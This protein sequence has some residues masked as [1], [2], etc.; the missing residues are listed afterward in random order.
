MLL[1]QYYVLTGKLCLLGDD[2]FYQDTLSFNTGA[3]TNITVFAQFNSS[4]CDEI[5]LDDFVLSY[6][7]AP[8][9]GIKAFFDSIRLVSHSLSPA[10]SQA[11]EDD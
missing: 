4:T 10:E 2:S 9:E 6:Q 11:A 5:R 7:G 1:E 8:D 3:H